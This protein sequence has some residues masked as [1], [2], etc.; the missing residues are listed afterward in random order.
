MV[1]GR[2]QAGSIVET[3]AP[4]SGEQES[5]TDR[6]YNQIVRAFEEASNTSG[7][8]YASSKMLFAENALTQSRVVS[9]AGG[10]LTVDGRMY[11]ARGGP[12]GSVFEPVV[13]GGRADGNP[14]LQ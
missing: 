1:A 13:M 2:M 14:P 3:G 6:V 8:R 12:R 10:E 4:A 9:D 5:Y 11:A 7:S